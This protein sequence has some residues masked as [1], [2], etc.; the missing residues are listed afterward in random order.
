MKYII[1]LS[2]LIFTWVVSVDHSYAQTD[3]TKV[4]NEKLYV[5][6]KNDGIQYIGKIISDDGRELLIITEKLGKIYIPKSEVKEIKLLENEKD[7]SNGEYSDTGPFTTRYAFTT[8]ALPISKGENYA[9]V[10]LY[11]PEVHFAVT[12]HLNVG[13]M[14]TWIGSPLALALKYTLPT[15]KEKLNFSVGT[16]SGSSG[17]LN[18]FQGFGGLHFA[19]MT[20]GNRKSNLTFAMGYAHFLSGNQTTLLVPGQ[21][22]TN[23]QYYPSFSTNSTYQTIKVPTIHGPMFSI[24]GITKVGPKAS[25]VFDSMLGYFNITNSRDNI[26]TTTLQEPDFPNGI[27]GKYQHT[28][29][30]ITEVR[31]TVAFFIM[32]GMRFQKDEKRAFQFSLAGV[33]VFQKSATVKENR[34][35]PLPMC[36][37]F[38][39]F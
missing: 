23:D 32:P 24:A 21:Y 1:L 29:T 30:T 2:L 12:N 22:T 18:N 11:G 3:T 13:V 36:S 31:Q 25:F 7:I 35:F 34:S 39:K 28:V 27:P 17:Y 6:T 4:E 33:S 26:Q 9:L 14:S 19:N 8:N 38:F 15:K 20:L 10:N 37:W 16:V 5:I